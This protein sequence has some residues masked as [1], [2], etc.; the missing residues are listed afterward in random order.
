LR[1]GRGPSL[2]LG[3]G[4]HYGQQRRNRSQR[5]HSPKR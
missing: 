5:D 3:S 2:S 1:C 4:G